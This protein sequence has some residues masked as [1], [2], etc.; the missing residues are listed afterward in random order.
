MISNGKKL[1]I[2]LLADD[3]SANTLAW[4]KALSEQGCGV[5][6]VSARSKHDY[7]NVIALRPY[8]LPSRLKF[9]L[10]EFHLREIIEQENPDLIIGY[11]VTSYGYLAA[12]SGFRPLVIAAQ[13]EKIARSESLSFVMNKILGIFARYAIKNADLIHAWS[14]NIRDGL[15]TF[16]CPEDKILTMHR[17]I[18]LKIFHPAENRKI[19]VDPVFISTRSLYPIYNIDKLLTAF[20]MLLKENPSCLL[21]IIGDGPEKNSLEK[22]SAR[23]GIDRNVRFSGKLSAAQTAEELRSSDIYV[24]LV[25]TEGMSSSLLEACACG[26]FPI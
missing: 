21:K 16:A 17:G 25:E 9:L 15:L 13:N 1:K 14:E 23:L 8:F 26:L 10:G 20:S 24:S 19:S 5:K 7:G 6:I 3:K 2:L 18:D 11:R 4:S 12:R 22:L